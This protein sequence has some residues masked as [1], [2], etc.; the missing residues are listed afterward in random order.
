MKTFRGFAIGFLCS[1]LLAAC[2]GAMNPPGP[3]SASSSAGS[4]AR[5]AAA[6]AGYKL[7]YAF[8]GTPDGASPY[9]GLVAIKNTLYGTTLNGSSNYCS[10]SCYNHCYLGCGTVFSTDTAGNE[11]VVYNFS[12]NF[13]SG[14]DG[15]WPFDSLTKM[16]GQLFG[17][18]GGAGQ[19]AD[20][21]VFTIDPSGHER[22]LYSFSGNTNGGNDG[23]SPEASLIGVHGCD[24]GRTPP[25]VG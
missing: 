14:Q 9:G 3:Q 15:S 1:L 7:L 2:G 6:S 17:T 12:G 16:S 19:F 8:K 21:T 4:H 5:S 13:N 18:T 20:G 23:A 22:V 25:R 24:C 10:Q 11:H